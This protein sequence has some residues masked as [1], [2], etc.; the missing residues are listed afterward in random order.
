[1]GEQSESDPI[2]VRKQGVCRPC[3]LLR[4]GC[5]DDDVYATALPPPARCSQLPCASRLLPKSFRRPQP[6]HQK[7]SFTSFNFRMVPVFTPSVTA[8]SLYCANSKATYGPQAKYPTR[9]R[10]NYAREHTSE[11]GV[12]QPQN[13]QQLLLLTIHV[14]FISSWELFRTNINRCNTTT[15]FA[16]LSYIQVQASQTRSNVRYVMRTSPMAH[17]TTKQCPIPGETVV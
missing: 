17:C 15:R 13:P 6:L 2:K 16:S 7:R 12:S 3:L 1:M 10:Y 9:D 8:I 5:D 4:A 11:L 14:H